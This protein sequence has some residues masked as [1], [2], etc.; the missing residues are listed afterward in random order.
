MKNIIVISGSHKKNGAGISLLKEFKNYFNES[1][2]SFETIH[3]SN[4]NIEK[5]QP[6]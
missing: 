6:P 1:E 3:L 2:Y 4:N 5:Q